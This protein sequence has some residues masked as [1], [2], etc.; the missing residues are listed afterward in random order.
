VLIFD[1]QKIKELKMMYGYQDEAKV[2]CPDVNVGPTNT[3]DDNSQEEEEEES[4]GNLSHVGIR[5]C[6]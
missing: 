6:G 5:V 4:E 2:G 1:E 3:K